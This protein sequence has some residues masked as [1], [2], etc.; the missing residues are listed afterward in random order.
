MLRGVF[1]SKREKL[2]VGCRKLHSEKLHNQYIKQIIIIIIIV[3]SM[4]G[5]KRMT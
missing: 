2:P 4:N 1:G 3:K 5:K